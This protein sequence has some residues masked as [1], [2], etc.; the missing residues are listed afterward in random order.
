MATEP[1]TMG[2]STLSSASFPVRLMI[3]PAMIDTSAVATIP[4]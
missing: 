2:G 1:V 3:S 4:P